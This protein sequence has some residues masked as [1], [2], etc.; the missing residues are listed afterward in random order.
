VRFVHAGE[1]MD[2]T[3]AQTLN[4]FVR[5]HALLMDVVED[6]AIYSVVAFAAAVAVLWLLDPP[7]RPGAFRLAVASGLAGAGFA[8]LVNQ[9]ITHLWERPRPYASHTDIVSVVAPSGDPS[10]PSDHAA[11]AF[12][13]AVGVL[14]VHRSAGRILLA[15]AALIAVSRVLT[16]MHYPS[17]V[18][19]GAVIGTVSAV[20]V[21]RFAL[22][23][24]QGAVRLA[25][26]ILDPIV[27]VLA[28]PR[29]VSRM[30]G[31]PPVRRA[32]VMVV[33]GVALLVFAYS[34]RQHLLDE[35]P[36]VVLGAWGAVVVL[37]AAVAGRS[38]GPSSTRLG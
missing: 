22:L 3:I 37:A 12:G 16:G 13:I 24:L 9:V 25:S 23:P 20:V 33:G 4:Q 1:G 8:L 27:A 21:V 15:W 29:V 11:A 6:F 35:M 34:L 10:F 36:L 28:R 17:D 18:V 19:A 5:D 32:T 31:S 2:T 30:V 26:A 38:T 7:G 14:L